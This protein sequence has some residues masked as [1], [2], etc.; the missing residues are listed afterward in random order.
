MRISHTIVAA[1]F[2]ALAA[3]LAFEQSAA[4]QQGSPVP[5]QPIAVR[6]STV[7]VEVPRALAVPESTPDESRPSPAGGVPAL[8][9]NV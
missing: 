5:V 8:T 4:A 1:S 6:A 9:R 3:T 2:T 7:K